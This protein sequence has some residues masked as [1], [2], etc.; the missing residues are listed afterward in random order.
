MHVKGLLATTI[1][2]VTLANFAR[3]GDPFL[4]T[5][6]TTSGTPQTTA[7]SGTSLPDLIGNLVKGDGPFTSFQNRDLSGSLRYGSLNNAVIV[8]KNAADTSA[9]LTI[10]SIG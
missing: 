10:P 8:T 3:G 9:T 6:Q 4:L 5:A 7:V 2:M 1:A